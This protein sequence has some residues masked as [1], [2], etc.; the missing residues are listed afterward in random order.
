MVRV[1]DAVRR[2]AP[3]DWVERA[4]L[5]ASMACL[6]HCLVLPVLFALLPVL[7]AVIPVP[8]AF[9][10]WMV[11]V[12][13]PLSG[14]ALVTGRARHRLWWPLATG[15]AGLG[16]LAAGAFLFGATW[17]DVPVTLAGGALLGV[18]H[19]GNWRL[20]HHA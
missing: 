13:V 12:A 2:T 14:A 3:V 10:A 1:G 20:R 6:V 19:L 15:A 5:G 4:A 18:A 9:H 16:F 11:V 17:A 7:S 8:E